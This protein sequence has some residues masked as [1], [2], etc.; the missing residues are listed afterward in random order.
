MNNLII[1]KDTSS[2]IKTYS[3]EELKSFLSISLEVSKQAKQELTERTKAGEQ[4]GFKMKVNETQKI[5]NDLESK[6]DLLSNF[7]YLY[8]S[9]YEELLKSESLSISI[10]KL[11]KIAEVK[12]TGESKKQNKEEFKSII[13]DFC[14]IAKSNKLIKA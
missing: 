6:K 2:L 13:S 3:N 11:A 7:I 10:P 9:S 5:K 1:N 14:Y 12:G 4:T 8:N